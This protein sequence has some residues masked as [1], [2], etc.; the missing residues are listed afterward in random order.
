MFLTLRVA[1]SITATVPPTSAETQTSEPSGVNW[2]KRGLVST[3]TLAMTSC[4]AV[5]MKW[6]M[7]VVSDVFAFA[8]GLNAH[9]L[10]L[11]AD[12]DLGHDLP[13][14]DVDGGDQIVVLVGDIERLAVGRSANSSGSAPDGKVP[15]ISSVGGVD[16]LHRVVVA[17]AE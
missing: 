7:L 1:V 2:A 3:S 11:D 12:R 17:G 10:R 6:A 5:S 16:H 8:V 9:A 13:A 14:V 4:F 15:T